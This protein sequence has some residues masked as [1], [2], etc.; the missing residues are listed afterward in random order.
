MAV[1]SANTSVLDSVAFLFSWQVMHQAAVKST[2]TGLP[3]ASSASTRP[4]AQACQRGL[5]CT[6][7]SAEDVSNALPGSSILKTFGPIAHASAAQA[8]IENVAK[9]VR[10]RPCRLKAQTT[11]DMASSS[12][13]RLAAPSTPL[14]CPSTHKSQTTV[15]NMGNAM[16]VRSATIHAPGRGSHC[17]MAGT[18]LTA[19]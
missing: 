3:A 11:R 5:P 7:P 13:S 17:A 19:R 2:N 10:L 12:A 4:G 15:A 8:A 16:K 14:K 6:A 1:K 9:T 18:Q